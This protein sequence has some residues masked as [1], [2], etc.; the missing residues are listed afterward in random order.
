[1]NRPLQVH[2]I[3]KIF[4]VL[5]EELFDSAFVLLVLVLELDVKNIVIDYLLRKNKESRRKH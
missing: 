1:M 2:Y 3:T 5:L 4:A